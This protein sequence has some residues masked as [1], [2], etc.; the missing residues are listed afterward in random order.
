MSTGIAAIQPV[1]GFLLILLSFS[2]SPFVVGF[3]QEGGFGIGSIPFANV[4]VGTRF[5]VWPQLLEASFQQPWLGWGLRQVSVAHNAVLHGYAVSEPFIYSHNIALDLVLGMGYPIGILTMIVVTAWLMR[6]IRAIGDI[7]SW[8]CIALVIPVAVHSQLE[9]PFTYA[10]FLLPVFFAVGVLEAKI[11]PASIVE[12][13]L[14]P[15]V[16]GACAVL[17]L[18]VWSAFEYIAVEEDYRVARFEALR[19]G[20]TPDNYDRP[21]IVLLTQMGA[22]LDV[23]RFIPA[24]GMP[25]GSMELARKVAMRFPWPA[26]QN[27]Y[28]LSLA[29]NGYP[30]EAI[31]QLKVMRAMHGEK[32]YE[33]TRSTWVELAQSK[34]P[35]L[36]QLEL[37]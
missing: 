17:A 1:I 26:T 8:Y 28:A 27:R 25:P 23:I 35:Q 20:R 30:D 13:H 9:F 21:T 34:Y 10:Y 33:S 2:V 12:V 19:I 24:P 36:I 18:M 11:V 22:V 37:P 6:R 31:R 16:W 7:N 3:L 29:L 32:M 15:V 14:R 5:T 4:S